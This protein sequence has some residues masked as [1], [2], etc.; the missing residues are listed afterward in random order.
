VTS[1]SRLKMIANNE[2][3]K[4]P[5]D[6]IPKAGDCLRRLRNRLGL[7]TRKV[8]EFSREV[9]AKQGSNEYAISHARLVQIEKQ[10]SIP[11]IYKLFTLSS[12]YGV[13]LDEL[14]AT[15][16]NADDAARLH[17]SMQFPQTHLTPLPHGGKKAIP[18]PVHFNSTSPVA[19]N[20]L[21]AHIVQ[22]WG[23]VPA[24]LLE[25]LNLPG[26]RY[27]FIGL[28][29]YTMYPLIRPGSIVQ[30]DHSQKI[31]RSARYRTEFD[32][33]IYFLESRSGYLC[34]WCEISRGHLTSI[35]HPLSPSGTQ[36]FAYP[37][38]VEIVGRVTGVAV[39]LVR[40]DDPPDRRNT[41]RDT[42]GLRTMMKDASLPAFAGL[43]EAGITA[44]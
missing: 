29:D 10:A 43:R 11:S 25:S 18:F 37:S 32:R 19:G 40:E 20:N 27:G 14:I 22:V 44:G 9:A 28:T 12:I 41:E 35:P 16:L 23:E 5:A 38:E 2:G 7:T 1:S 31:I 3:V 6:S 39:R 33:P 24:P 30:I 13:P 17:V 42:A 21:V 34:S 36:V 15:Y 8:A 26:F 4:V